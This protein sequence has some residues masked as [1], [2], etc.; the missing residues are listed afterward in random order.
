MARK[1]TGQP[2]GRRP[3]TADGTRAV[4]SVHI[5]LTE[6]EHMR[7]VAIAEAAGYASVS[8]YVRARCLPKD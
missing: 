3:R 8:D 7:L 4:R 6:L 2:P 1:P 5:K